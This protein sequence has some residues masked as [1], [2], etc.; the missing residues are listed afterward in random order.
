MDF[1]AE[2]DQLVR[3]ADNRIRKQGPTPCGST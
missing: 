3:Y 1:R 2:R